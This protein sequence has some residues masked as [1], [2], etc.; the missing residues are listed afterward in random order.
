MIDK[1]YFALVAARAPAWHASY[2][3]RQASDGDVATAPWRVVICDVGNFA[4]AAASET[5][6][7]PSRSPLGSRYLPRTVGNPK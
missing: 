6:W 3:Q 4:R 1:P 7:S 2:W 5:I